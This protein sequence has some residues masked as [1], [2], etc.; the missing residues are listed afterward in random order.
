LLVPTLID[1]LRDASVSMSAGEAVSNGQDDPSIV[2]VTHPSPHKNHAMAVDAARIYYEDLGGTLPLTVTGVNSQWVD[3]ASGQD[4]RGSRAFRHAP[5]VLSHTRFIG[6]VSDSRYLH[7]I[8]NAAVVWH[9]VIIDNGT[10]VAFDAARAD[11]HFVS[12]DYPQIR[13][14]CD[15]YGVAAIWHRSDDPRGAAEALRLAEGRFRAGQQPGHN[16][17][18]DADEERINAYG[19]VLKRLFE[20]ADA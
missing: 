17:R 19:G 12:S 3:P 1:P 20:A 9:N 11:R 6:E 15:R 14:L 18:G 7:L 16:L 4:T 2:W 5:E 13:Y 8:R 10:F